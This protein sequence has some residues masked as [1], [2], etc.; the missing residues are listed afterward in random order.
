MKTALVLISNGTE[1]I[2]MSTIVDVMRRGGVKVTLCAVATSE[3]MCTC[4]NG[5]M[6]TAD[7]SMKELLSSNENHSY[8]MLVVPGGG[9]GVEAFCSVP[10]VFIIESLLIWL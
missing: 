2:E 9:K 8:D 7:V 5:L 4:A 10:A 3:K 1:D 6:V